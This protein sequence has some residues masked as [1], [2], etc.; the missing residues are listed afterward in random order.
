[1]MKSTIFASVASATSL[2]SLIEAHLTT[3]ASLKVN[4][5]AL[6]LTDESSHGVTV[7]DLDANSSTGETVEGV[8]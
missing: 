1:M 5:K 3:L 6:A 4:E 8:F 2:T 7:I